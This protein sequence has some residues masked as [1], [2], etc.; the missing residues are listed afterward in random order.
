MPTLSHEHR[1]MR[2]H[3][4][5]CMIPTHAKRNAVQTSGGLASLSKCSG[6]E[7]RGM[8]SWE[9]ISCLRAPQSGRHR[10]GQAQKPPSAACTKPRTLSPPPPP[11]PRLT[12]A[13]PDGFR[14]RGQWLG[15][16]S[17]ASGPEENMEGPGKLLRPW[18]GGTGQRKASGKASSPDPS[19]AEGPWPPL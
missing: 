11:N 12:Q 15:A 7:G 3:A 13:I 10:D 14:A 6:P 5:R 16:P 9:L 2:T 19:P 18:V 1:Q 17:A 8:G 4:T